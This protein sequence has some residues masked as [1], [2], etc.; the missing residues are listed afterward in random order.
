MPSILIN[1]I[2]QSWI[3]FLCF[4]FIF[5]FIVIG[6]T[7]LT[8]NTEWII[9]LGVKKITINKSTGRRSTEATT[10]VNVFFLDKLRQCHQLKFHSIDESIRSPLVSNSNFRTSIWTLFN[11]QL[12]WCAFHC[13]CYE[14]RK[15]ISEFTRWFCGPR[16]FSRYNNAKQT[17]DITCNQCVP[18]T[19]LFM[20][21]MSNL[22]HFIPTHTYSI[23][24]IVFYF[25]R[26]A[27]NTIANE[28]LNMYRFLSY[29]THLRHPNIA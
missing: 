27:S 11:N 19:L 18:Y 2:C 6:V 3:Y 25:C 12:K 16:F 22:C 17:I 7:L 29:E 28:R 26:Q 4:S 24:S 8:I 9:Y 13:R 14:L 5:T 23:F 10:M 1:S 21:I 15:L 20:C